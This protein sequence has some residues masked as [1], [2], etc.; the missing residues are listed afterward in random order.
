MGTQPQLD[1]IEAIRSRSNAAIFLPLRTEAWSSREADQRTR[2]TLSAVSRLACLLET[3][4]PFRAYIWFSPHTMQT[5][6]HQRYFQEQF[7]YSVQDGGLEVASAGLLRLVGA[8]ANRAGNSVSLEIEHPQ[9]GRN[10]LTT[11]NPHLHASMREGL[12]HSQ[13]NALPVELELTVL[14]S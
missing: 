5:P 1:S 3:K 14:S 13:I 11:V 6:N 10:G 7:G 2:S 9:T 8:R 12:G 4:S